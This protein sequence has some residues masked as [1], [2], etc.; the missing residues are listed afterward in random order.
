M[1]R[2]RLIALD[3]DG[4][5]LD[6]RKH[7][8]ADNRAALQEADRRGI[9]V[10]IAS[11]RMIS[12]IEPIERQLGIDCILIAYN[13]AMV[14]GQSRKGRTVLAHRPIPAAIAEFFIRFSREQGCLLNFYHEDRLYAE[15][16]PQSRP[17]ME[18]YSART[19]A[20]Y[21]LVG[22]L[23]KDFAGVRPTKLMLLTDRRERDRLHE[24]LG[25]RF[26][27]RAFIT[28]SEPEYLE[29]MAAGVDKGSAFSSIEDHYGIPADEIMAVGDAE[30]DIAMLRA[31]GLGVALANSAPEVRAAA[32]V[33]TERT[34]NQGGVAEAVH[35]WALA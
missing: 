28:K 5:L 12:S 22:S 1:K 9:L 30:N 24:N 11:G 27:G 18:L 16:G 31:A 7:L 21:N 29:I 25:S 2:I 33:V 26:R 10:S 14:I 20:E 4:S 34:N 19:G 15:D 23:E 8:P 6:D 35:R 17:F 32:H 13:G 3:L